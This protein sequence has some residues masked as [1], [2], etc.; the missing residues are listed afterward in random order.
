VLPRS[1]LHFWQGQ[2]LPSSP[3]RRAILRG[4]LSL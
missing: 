4:A 1:L 2:A 3:F